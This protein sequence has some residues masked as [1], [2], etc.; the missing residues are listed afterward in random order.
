MYDES[1]RARLW[2]ALSLRGN[3]LPVVWINF[4]PGDFGPSSTKLAVPQVLAALPSNKGVQ[5]DEH[6]PF[7]VH[8]SIQTRDGGLYFKAIVPPGGLR[9]ERSQTKADERFFDGLLVHQK[10]RLNTKTWSTHTNSHGTAG[11]VPSKPIQ[12]VQNPL[13]N[14]I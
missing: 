8:E 1:V 6:A 10:F 11:F 13:H 3:A 7:D 12:V 2:Q 14:L 9:G 5:S 4:N